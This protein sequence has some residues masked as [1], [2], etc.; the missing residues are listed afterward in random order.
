MPGLVRYGDGV[1]I[2]ESNRI[3]LPSSVD[4]YDDD[5]QLVGYATSINRTDTRTV[6]PQRHLSSDDAARII[7]QTPQPENVQVTVE[8]FSLYN[9][10]DLTG[11][12][13]H[14]TLAARLSKGSGVQGGF[15]GIYLFKSINSQKIPFNMREVT[16]HPATG[17][18]SIL[19]WRGCM[20]VE[21]SQVTNIGQA[22]ETQTARIQVSWIDESTS[23]GSNP[24]GIV[25]GA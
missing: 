4:L 17:A 15:G 11:K 18:T 19:W 6:D 16:K 14:Y 10:I 23:A 1:G 20:L 7:E 5:G 25:I 13:P 9:K 24:G 21:F 12:M 2:P 22:T 8:G 3:V